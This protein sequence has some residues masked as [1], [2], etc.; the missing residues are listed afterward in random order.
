MVTQRF[1]KLFKVYVTASKILLGLGN[2]RDK[3]LD[4]RVS[5]RFPRQII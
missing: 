5:S 2:E 1:C 3:S 4:V